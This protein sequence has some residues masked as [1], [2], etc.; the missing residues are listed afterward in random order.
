MADEDR[1]RAIA[2]YTAALRASREIEARATA[3]R[4]QLREARRKYDQSESDITAL[5]S[6][7]Q[8]IGE[9]LRQL[10]ED[11]FIIKKSSGPRHVVGVRRKLDKAK[12]VSGTRVTLDITT[13]PTSTKLFGS[14]ARVESKSSTAHSLPPI[15]H[16]KRRGFAPPS[17]F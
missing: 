16:K 2:A 1:T 14:C 17:L 12:L 8:E 7:G 4:E 3:K 9:V 15:S 11:R 5:Q 6:V 10:D 13:V